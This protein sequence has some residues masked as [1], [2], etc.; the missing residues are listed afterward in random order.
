[1]FRDGHGMILFVDPKDPTKFVQKVSGKAPAFELVKQDG[2]LVK[3]P[4][5]SLA[6]GEIGI[7]GALEPDK[8]A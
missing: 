5:D 8:Q 1:M 6:I 3:L 2:E 7:D 4:V